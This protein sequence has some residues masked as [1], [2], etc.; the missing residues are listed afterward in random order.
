MS[1]PELFLLLHGAFSRPFPYPVSVACVN[2]YALM[3]NNNYEAEMDIL[4]LE[5]LN[6]FFLHET[7]INRNPP[8]R[9]HPSHPI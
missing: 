6:F 4:F 3:Q 1:S 5:V 9:G 2:A 8:Q 7:N